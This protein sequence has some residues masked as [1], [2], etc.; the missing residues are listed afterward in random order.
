MQRYLRL[1]WVFLRFSLQNDAAYRADFLGQVITAFVML[2]AEL[3]G[4]WTIYSNTDSIADWNVWQ[5]LT[6]LGVFRI[7]TGA[8]SMFI[9]P[10]MRN[11]MESVREGTLDYVILK[12]ANTQFL[13]SL[14]RI[15]VWRITDVLLGIAVACYAGYRLG[16]DFSLGRL[17]LFAVLLGAGVVTIYS[18]WLILATLSFW[19]TRVSNIEMVFWN[20]FEAGRYPVDIYRPWIRWALTY[21]IPLAFLTTVPAGTLVGKTTGWTLLSAVAL[22]AGSFVVG[23][24]FW[25]LGLRRYS[26]ASA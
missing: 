7:M 16:M 12:P 5:L 8:I 14:R 15:V 6:L 17:L 19:F 24:A 13:A 18:L 3:V 1:A 2:G 26:G 23:S 25:R 9:A 10:N 11:L 21:V 4:L 22:A 20:I